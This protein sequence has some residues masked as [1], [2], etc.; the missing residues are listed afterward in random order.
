MWC[1]VSWQ[2]SHCF[3]GHLQAGQALGPEITDSRMLRGQVISSSN[4][5]YFCRRF[6]EFDVNEL[7]SFSLPHLSILTVMNWFKKLK[8]VR[9]LVGG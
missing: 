1:I 3:H 4:L 9:G 5:E 2:T 8:R 6:T 7:E